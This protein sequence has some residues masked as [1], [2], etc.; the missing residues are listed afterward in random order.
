MTEIGNDISLPENDYL[1]ILDVITKFNEC[2]TRQE[3]K[4]T[5]QE[6]LLPLFEAQAGLYGWTHD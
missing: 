1:A 2:E 6:H 4:N 5:T 3:L